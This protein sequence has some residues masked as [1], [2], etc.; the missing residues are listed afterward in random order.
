ME[1][2]KLGLVIAKEEKDL[3]ELKHFISDEW[4]DVF[5][6]PEGYLHSDNLEEACSIIR[7][8]NKWLITSMKDKRK[9]GKIFQTGIIIGPGGQVVGEHKK[10]SITQYENDYGIIAGD[11]IDSVDTGI[12]KIGLSICFELHF[13]EISRIYAL[14]GSRIIFNPIGTG[15]W[16]GQQYNQWNAVALARAAENGVFVVGC[17][18][19]NDAIPIAF[20]YAPG[21]ECLVQTKDANKLIPVELDYTKYKPWTFDQR[22]PELYQ[23]LVKKDYSK[24]H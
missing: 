11:S 19:Y 5:L 15:M 13:P 18:H 16:N 2:L 22:R 10:T 9:A 21:G 12:G 8:N 4:P 24:P 6:F 23:E 3:S 7:K 1:K 20:A 14:Q 17:S